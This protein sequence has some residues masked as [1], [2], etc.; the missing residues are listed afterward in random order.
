M[1]APEA[2]HRLSEFEMH[3]NSHSIVKLAVH[4]PNMQQ[5]FFV[6]GEEQAAAD[7]AAES[8]T[9]LT[10]WFKLNADNEPARRHLYREI[11]THYV[12]DTSANPRRWK[13]RQRGGDKIIARMFS[14][15]PRDAERFHLRLLLLHV[16]GA[17]CFE[18]VRTV[19]GELLPTFREACIRRHLLEDDNIWA[20]TMHEAAAVRMPKQLRI[21]FCAILTL[22]TPASPAELW[23]TFKVHLAEDF[24][25]AQH[26][27]RAAENLALAD[28]QGILRQSG[29]CRDFIHLYVV[30]I[31]VSIQ[32]ALLNIANHNK[33]INN[34]FYITHTFHCRLHPHAT[35]TS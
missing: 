33:Q 34:I 2:F 31:F 4:L 35:R 6:P 5:V 24:E 17:T 9:T 22:G 14:V 29:E 13:P 26:D 10:A 20:A 27:Q 28:I 1:S 21:L 23:Q 12:F 25:R 3:K 32:F 30:I 15:S 16:E 8:E 11:P 7:R 19:D 18:D